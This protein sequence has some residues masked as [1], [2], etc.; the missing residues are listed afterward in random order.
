M[1]KVFIPHYSNEVEKRVLKEKATMEEPSEP[2]SPYAMEYEKYMSS[3]QTIPFPDMTPEFGKREE[4]VLDVDFRLHHQMEYQRHPD[5]SYRWI[6]ISH[7][8]YKNVKDHSTCRIIAIAIEGK[9]DREEYDKECGLSKDEWELEKIVDKIR[10]VPTLEAIGI[11]R[12]LST[13][14]S[15]EQPVGEQG[16]GAEFKYRNTVIEIDAIQYIGNG[17][18]ETPGLPDWI[19]R[20]FE[21]KTLEATNGCDPL[22]LTAHGKKY[23]VNPTDYIIK[24]HG[25]LQVS[26]YDAFHAC[27]ER[28]AASHSQKSDAS[29]EQRAKELYPYPENDLYKEGDPDLQEM[30][31]HV[32]QLRAAYLAGHSSQPTDAVELAEWIAEHDYKP[33]TGNEHWYKWNGMECEEVPY[34]TT[35]L[36]SLFKQR[37]K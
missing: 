16:E 11:L 8:K 13:T 29:V 5:E 12:K 19:W 28:I 2:L 20:A 37:G 26:P 7:Q 36:Y 14:Q 23:T 3:L 27:Y 24:R 6:D 4:V 35:E 10:S 22:R 34:T 31:W 33:G 17:N 9:P 15:V 21:D 30:I 25:Y 18:F 1:T 32:D